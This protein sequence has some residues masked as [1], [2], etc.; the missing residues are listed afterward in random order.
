[1]NACYYWLD[2][3]TYSRLP[4]MLAESVKDNNYTIDFY[5]YI[6]THAY[7]HAEK[8]YPPPHPD[9]HA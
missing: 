4:S 5:R 6:H 8:T 3:G 9:T 7:A 1:M 2:S